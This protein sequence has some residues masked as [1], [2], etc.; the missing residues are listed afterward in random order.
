MV[1]KGSSKNL[2][3]ISEDELRKG[4]QGLRYNTLDVE[5]TV[6]ECMKDA[7]NECREL[8]QLSHKALADGRDH[9]AAGHN[10]KANSSFAFAYQMRCVRDWIWTRA[11]GRQGDQGHAKYMQLQRQ[12]GQLASKNPVLSAEERRR[13]KKLINK[14]TIET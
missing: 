13:I 7:G 5:R 4:L 12:F 6:Q 9:M 10:A 2:L 11:L 8:T 14:S 3:K 1:G